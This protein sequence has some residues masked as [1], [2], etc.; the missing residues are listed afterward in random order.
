M[1]GPLYCVD[2]CRWRIKAI[3]AGY[4]VVGILR[5]LELIT[6]LIFSD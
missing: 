5:Q 6:V 1:S 4:G 2:D 3:N